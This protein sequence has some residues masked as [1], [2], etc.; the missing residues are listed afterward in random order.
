MRGTCPDGAVQEPGV[1]HVPEAGRS[2]L[3]KFS[4][5]LLEII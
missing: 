4:G 2:E 1:T 5:R 3:E